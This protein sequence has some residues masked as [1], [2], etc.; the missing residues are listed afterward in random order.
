M[1]LS[2]NDQIKS[3]KLMK[4]V[5][6]L[7]AKL[8]REKDAT[9]RERL[10]R[11]FRLVAVGYLSLVV[12]PEYVLER[13]IR[14]YRTIAS[15][16]DS[17]A[18]L[19]FRF[20]RI[21][22]SR[23]QTL[24]RIPA[25]VTFS[26]RTTMSGE[27]LL[28]R[29]LYELVSGECQHSICINV[30][31]RDAPT[32]SR[33]F[34]WFINYMYSTFKHLVTDNLHWWKRNGFFTLSAEAIS[35][36]VGIGGLNVAHFI[37]CN[38]LSTSVV[39]GG[40]AEGGANAAR[41][42]DTIQRAFY[43]GWKSVHGLKHQTVNNAYGFTVDM[44]GPTSLRRNDLAVLALSDINNRMAAVQ[45]GDEVQLIIFGDSAYHRQS[46]ISSYL[47]AEDGI[48]NYLRYNGG[49]KKVRISIEWDYGYTATL[50]VYL[51]KKRKLQVLHSD[52]V[53]RVYT[54]ATLMRNFHTA[55]YGCQTS[56]YFELVIPESFLDNYI[57][58]T[59]F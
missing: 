22:L 17:D 49:L 36:K 43:N 10:Q 56:N 18:V 54:V 47:V 28:L 4:L 48:E 42:D 9:E 52:T 57:N 35:T 29:A 12:E 8:D 40:P 11:A 24:L 25:T 26:N 30:F 51:Q 34:G 2:S 15:F 55:L 32:Q 41:W 19:L 21:H 1:A 3:R 13:P 14:F 23:L 58:Q 33:A 53:A 38:C 50:F 44:C 31:G 27:E 16:T 5:L 37:D 45:E 39:G 6:I 59:D 46:H 20:Q 7:A